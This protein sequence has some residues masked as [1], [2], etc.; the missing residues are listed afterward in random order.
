MSQVLVPGNEGSSDP[1]QLRAEMD[2]WV[3]SQP[4]Q[5]MVAAFG[6]PARN[7]S[8]LRSYLASL[9]R[10]TGGAWDFRA[11]RERNLVDP[12]LVSADIEPEVLS[13]AEALGLVKPSPPQHHS[14]DY[15]LVLGGLVRACVW[16]ARYAALLAPELH[17]KRVDGLTAF[18]RIGGDEPRLLKR[19]RLPAL[20]SEH[21]IMAAALCRAFSLAAMP[22]R[23]QSSETVSTNSRWLLAEAVTS[24]GLTVGEVVAPSGE[25]ESRRANSGDTYSFWA[26]QMV[27][28]NP[29]ARILLVTSI[30]YVPHQHAAALEMLGIPYG[31]VVN[32]VGVDPALVDDKRAPQAF[33]GVHYLQEFRSTVRSF[34]S[35][36][37]SLGFVTG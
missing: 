25:P 9:D 5:A 26:E 13:A 32:T 21:E 29:G 35:L 20:D 7:G 31:V 4:F 27:A 15:I 18:R 12:E 33:R 28:L 11:K 19:F 17:P 10:F 3:S 6:G 2:A 1:T 37:R 16:R 22:P 14:Y 36:E 34:A 23:A 30:I 8:D 24:Y